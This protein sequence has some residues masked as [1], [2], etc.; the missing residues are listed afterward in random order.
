MVTVVNAFSRRK[1]GGYAHVQKVSKREI[2]APYRRACKAEK[3]TST[4]GSRFL[5]IFRALVPQ[6]LLVLLAIASALA[7]ST[8]SALAAEDTFGPD[9]PIVAIRGEPVFLG[10][11]NLILTE[12]L[13]PRDLERLPI[14]VQQATAALLVR[15]H[16]AMRSLKKQ[17]G[18][19]LES[20]IQREIQSQA[21]EAQRRGTSLA[22]LAKARMAN[23]KSLTS[24]IAWRT[25]WSQYLKS[26]LTDAN[27]RRYFQQ[28]RDRYAGGRWEV[29]QIFVKMES[30]DSDSVQ[31]SMEGLNELAQQIRESGAIE[32]AFADAA[33]L[34][35]DS[36]SAAE[37]GMVGWVEKDGDLP[38]N[39][40][41]AVR[42]TDAGQVSDPVKSPLG[43]HLVLVH[44]YEPG[45]LEF[46][47]LED[48][49]QLRRDAANELFNSLVRRQADAKITWFIGALRPPPTVPLIPD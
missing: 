46:E 39:V 42:T 4:L 17:G 7:A 19:A 30:N 15:R 25:A 32:S 43:L 9:D 34:H 23:E 11:L 13:K 14:E 49:A 22:A 21:A 31:A 29:S 35:S 12:R 10:E 1:R 6:F 28:H 16:L 24:D 44:R 18:D 20:M 27:L 26:R 47:E 33:R 41:A 38:S 3:A 40:M 2:G 5:F 8:H 45:K 48:Q 37:G 36:G